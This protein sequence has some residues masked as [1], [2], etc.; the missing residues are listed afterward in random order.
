MTGYRIHHVGLT[1]TDIDKVINFFEKLGFKL[2]K[3]VRNEERRLTLAFLRSDNFSIELYKWDDVSRELD[4]FHLPSF[5]HL[6]FIVNSVDEVAEKLREL[7]R[8]FPF[9]LIF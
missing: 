3:I 5:H 2:E 6:A 8:D 4:I 9:E 1:I 7:I